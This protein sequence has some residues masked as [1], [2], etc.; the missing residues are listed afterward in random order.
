MTKV[1]EKA[2]KKYPINQKLFFFES[3]LQDNTLAIPYIYE[4]IIEKYP[5]FT[6]VWHI[7]GKPQFQ[8]IQLSLKG[9]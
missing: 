7:P 4:K 8:E 2:I 6:Y 1:Y 3:T 5:N 9:E